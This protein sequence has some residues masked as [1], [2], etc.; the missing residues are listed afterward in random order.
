MSFSGLGGLSNV[1][2]TKVAFIDVLFKP[3]GAMLK[4]QM[5]GGHHVAS[6]FG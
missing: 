5:F 3:F 4:Q 1:L 2:L 6:R